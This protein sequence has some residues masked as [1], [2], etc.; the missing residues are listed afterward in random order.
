MLLQFFNTDVY[1]VAPKSQPSTKCVMATA[2]NRTLSRRA[3][4]SHADFSRLAVLPLQYGV[5]SP[6]WPLRVRRQR[7]AIGSRCCRGRRVEANECNSSRNRHRLRSLCHRLLRLER[8]RMLRP[9]PRPILN[10]APTHSSPFLV[11]LSGSNYLCV[12]SCACTSDWWSAT[13]HGQA[14]CSRFFPG[15]TAF[16]ITTRYGTQ[17]QRLRTLLRMAQCAA[18]SRDSDS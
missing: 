5:P 8:H 9:T 13:C 14:R 18:S 16:G 17:F 12:S 4:F 15:H 7:A 10:P 3:P 1:L 6:G 11:G 2:L